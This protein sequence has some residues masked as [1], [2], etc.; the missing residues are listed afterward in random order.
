MRICS[1]PILANTPP[2]ATA[3][4]GIAGGSSGNTALVPLESKNIDLSI[5]VYYA[6]DSYVSMGLFNKQVDNFVGSGYVNR[7]LFG[8]RDPSSGAP[9]T[10]SGDAL[11]ALQAIPG[12]VIER[13]E[14]V[15]H[16]EPDCQCAYTRYPGGHDYGFNNNSTSGSFNQALP[17]IS[18]RPITLTRPRPIRC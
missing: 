13:R 14:P 18:S 15:G 3:L 12:A 16:D 8:L 4:G 7:N 5:E 9:G 1:W 2:R 11:A 10:F 6:N 17:T